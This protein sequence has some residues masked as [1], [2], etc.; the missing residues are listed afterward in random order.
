MLVYGLR[1]AG[2]IDHS[3]M[4]A[5]LPPGLKLSGTKICGPTARLLSSQIIAVISI[6]FVCSR[7]C[8]LRKLHRAFPAAASDYFFQSVPRTLVA[9]V[10]TVNALPFA[11]ASSRVA[12]ASRIARELARQSRNHP[13]YFSGRHKIDNRRTREFKSGI[14]ALVAG[15]GCRGSCRASSAWIISGVA[16]RQTIAASAK[17][18]TDRWHA[19]QLFDR[20]TQTRS[21]SA[22][23]PR[24][25][26]DAVK[27]LRASNGR[28]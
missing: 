17:S 23:L 4:A 25:C 11:T 2:R 20:A 27:Q 21:T 24:N 13:D 9:A 5:H 22:R 6:R 3:R 14:G 19:S 8:R 15:T 26:V 16:E 10:V 1:V 28:H 7:R 12:K 18:S